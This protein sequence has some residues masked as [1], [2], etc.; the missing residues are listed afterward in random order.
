MRPELADRSGE[1]PGRFGKEKIPM[2]P[3]LDKNQ[4][5][6][7]AGRVEQAR[8]EVHH[9]SSTPLTRELLRLVEHSM[10]AN[11]QWT[12][13][14]YSQPEPETRPR[15]LLC[16]IM[17]GER[18]WFERIAGEEKTQTF[19]PVL[20]REELLGGLEDNRRI[21][22]RLI[23][24]SLENVIHFKR[25]TGEKYHARVVDIIH[26]L[27]THG[28]HHRGQLAAHYARKGVAYPNTDHIKFLMENG[29]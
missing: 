21:F 22:Q 18:I 27:L 10:W 9:P 23:A 20:E 11:R 5:S 2:N 16:H 1:V 6:Q 8:T 7:T 15:E 26:H 19:F 29:L 28:Y 14:V 17:V 13:F 3:T 4:S 25:A 12:E 24:T